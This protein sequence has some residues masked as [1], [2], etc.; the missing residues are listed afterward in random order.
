MNAVL[1]TLIQWDRHLFVW[2][3]TGLSNPFFDLVLPWCRERF[4]WAPLYLFIVSYIGMIYGKKSWIPLLGLLLAVGLTDQVSS[5]LVKKNIERPRPCREVA[6]EHQVIMRVECGSGFSFT[7]SHAANHFAVAIFVI[8]LFG[9]VRRWVRPALLS[10]AALIAFSQ[11]YVGLHYPGDV[12]GGAMI[13]SLIAWG[14][15]NLVMRYK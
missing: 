7:S 8:G 9:R 15:V 5:T 11:V 3:N 1:E 12:L 2:I 13:G 4:F 6:L 14:V 10:W